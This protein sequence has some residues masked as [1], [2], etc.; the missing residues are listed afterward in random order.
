[1]DWNRDRMSEPLTSNLRAT[2]RV[3]H[4]ESKQV[5]IVVIGRNEG[6]R[7]VNCLRSLADAVETV[8]YVDSGS[9]D[10]SVQAANRSGAF[11]VHLDLTRPFTAARARNEGFAALLAANPGIQYV[12]FIDGDCELVPGWINFGSRFLS[13][14][15][16]IAIVCGRRRERHPEASIYNRLCDAEWETPVGQAT[17]CGGDAMIRVK[18]FVALGGYRE[19]LIAGEEPELCLRLRQQGWKIWRLDSEMTKHDAAISRFSQWWRRAVRGGFGYEEV[20]QLHKCRS[21]RIYEHE[22]RRA[23][24]WGGLLPLAICSAALLHPG[25]F[26]A[27]L[28]YPLQILRIALRRSVTDPFS[29][30]Y[31]TFMV[32]AKF[33]ELEGIVKFTIRQLDGRPSTLIEYKHP[34]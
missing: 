2:T 16:D 33:A 28:I 14:R 7:L 13:E 9:T 20:Y 11:V 3:A 31:G 6:D 1:M 18:A 8:I 15:E 17:A 29:W 30:A 19:Q 32:I 27:A 10:G 5:G 23:L 34:S 22:V 25:A 24:I 4:Q 21:L 12:Q 26:A